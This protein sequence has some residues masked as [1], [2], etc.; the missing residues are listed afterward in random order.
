MLQ[1]FA[2]SVADMEIPL[3]AATR[4]TRYQYHGCSLP[5]RNVL[6]HTVS[7]I[8]STRG[9]KVLNRLPLALALL[10]I[11]L[12]VTACSNPAAPIE[13]IPTVRFS[14]QLPAQ[15][16]I[17]VSRG[18]VD[19]LAATI[20]VDA[21]NIDPM[22]AV[23]VQTLG[24]RIIKGNQQIKHL[25][26]FVGSQQIGKTWTASTDVPMAPQYDL[27]MDLGVAFVG[28]GVRRGS[29]DIKVDVDSDAAIG[30]GFIVGLTEIPGLPV[31]EVVGLQP[32]VVVQTGTGPK[33]TICS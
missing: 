23:G 18:A 2:V 7:S 15:D 11:V 32:Q 20:H 16:G 24:F 17:C 3:D 6:M 33:L 21:E 29:F 13:K 8:S 27:W 31:V 9:F 26:V 30:D 12:A 1:N 10:A 25:R 5:P 4:H 28:H 19:V 14:V 22:L